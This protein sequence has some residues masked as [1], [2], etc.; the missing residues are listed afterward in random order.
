MG[1]RGEQLGVGIGDAGR[2]EFEQRRDAR[3]HGIRVDKPTLITTTLYS[4][5]RL[6]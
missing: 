5:I 3:E 1:R 6:V 2:I 4:L